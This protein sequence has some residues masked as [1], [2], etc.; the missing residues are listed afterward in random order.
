MVAVAATALALG[1]LGLAHALITSVA[2]DPPPDREVAPR[3]SSRR[4]GALT[5]AVACALLALV[6]AAYALPGSSVI[7][8]LM[9]G[10]A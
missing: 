5:A 8:D 7:A 9:R 10:V 2:G 3:R 1:F 4:L 6:V